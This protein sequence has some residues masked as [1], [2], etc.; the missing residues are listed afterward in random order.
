MLTLRLLGHLHHQLV[1]R[2]KTPALLG[3]A[4]QTVSNTFNL[5]TTMQ[6]TSSQ[7]EQSVINILTNII[8]DVP[9]DVKNYFLQKHLEKF[10]T[11]LVASQHPN[12]VTTRG[13]SSNASHTTF[14]SLGVLLGNLQRYMNVSNWMSNLSFQRG[15]R[16][17]RI[18]QVNPQASSQPEV[19]MRSATA[20]LLQAKADFCTAQSLFITPAEKL[21]MHHQEVRPV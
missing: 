17:S 12:Q 5:V 3:Q 16:N 21:R 15:H 9:D 19:C 18:P 10:L 4:I 13:G 20:W 8:R 11:L 7:Q 2:R 1:V 14:P 6:S